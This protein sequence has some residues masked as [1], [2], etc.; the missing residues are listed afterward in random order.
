MPSQPEMIRSFRF[1]TGNLRMRARA[2]AVRDLRERGLVPLEPLPGCAVHVQITKWFVPGAGILS[3]A[4]CGLRQE[5]RTQGADASDDL[6]FGVNLA[7]GS[8]ALQRGREITI[9]GGDAV[10][11][12]DAAG[13]FTITRPTPV[14]FIGLRVPR[15]ALAP[16]I[17]GLDGP[18]MRLIPGKTDTLK[19]LTRYVRAITDCQMLAIPET[20][21]LLVTHLHD[22]IA[23]S[24]GATRDAAVAAEGRGVRAARL[25]AIKAAIDANLGDD[26][27]TLSAVAAHHGVTPRYVHKLF[28]SEGITYTQFVLRQRLDRGYRMLRDPRFAARSISSIAYDVGFGDLSYFNRAFRRHYNATPS[29]IRN[30][31]VRS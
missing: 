17:V 2:D 18:A 5:A 11:L 8:T 26:S 6:F 25:Q 31:G 29:D 21:R 24:V 14:R 23:L 27:L 1:S 12:S 7:G 20:A 3:G 4:L 19:L 10:L 13:P 28:E 22:L 30:F 16:L 9:Q 15:Q